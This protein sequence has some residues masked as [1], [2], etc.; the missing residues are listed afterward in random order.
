[1]FE[2]RIVVTGSSGLIGRAVINRMEAETGACLT[3]FDIRESDPGARADL[4]DYDAVRRAL[5]DAVG[6]IHLGGMS[7]VIWGERSP[8]ACWQINVEATRK[9]LALALNLPRRPWVI[10]ASSREVYGKQTDF[11]VPETAPLNPMNAYARSK[12]AAEQLVWQARD[13]GLRAAVVRFSSVYG[14]V[15]DHADRLVPALAFVAAFGGTMRLDGPDC[16][17]DFTH[18]E[19]VARGLVSVCA[20]LSAGERDLP[21]LHF[22]SGIGTTLR[23]LSEIARSAAAGSSR[24]TVTKAPSRTFDVAHFCGD[25]RRAAAILGWKTSI[26]LREGISRLIADYI[27]RSTVADVHEPVYPLGPR[28]DSL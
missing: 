28:S 12:C 20:L 21:P 3:R 10:Y 2:E 19:D 11:P 27:A 24:I 16:S 7:R 25:P 9:I 23:E 15:D 8:S 5:A 26:P 6:V 18:V 4:R 22:V 17:F 14:N 1:M 13:A